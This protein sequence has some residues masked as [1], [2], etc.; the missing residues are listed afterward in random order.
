MTLTINIKGYNRAFVER[1]HP[2]YNCNEIAW[3]DDC[4]CAI[5]NEAENLSHWRYLED[6]VEED[7]ERDFCRAIFDNQVSEEEIEAQLK[8]EGFTTISN[9]GLYLAE[10]Y[11]KIIRGD[12]EMYEQSIMKS[13]IEN[14]CYQFDTENE[15]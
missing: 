15:D 3:L 9:F 5:D 13:A 11:Q 2:D 7:W 12:I 4:Y 14:F 6:T 1:F 10:K 8:Y